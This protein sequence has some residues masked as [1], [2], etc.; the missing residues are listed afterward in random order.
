MNAENLDWVDL[1]LRQVVADA[2]GLPVGFGHDVRAGCLAEARFGAG[3][4]EPD[5][6]YVSVGTGIAAALVLR[7]QVYAG[8][9]YAGRSGTGRP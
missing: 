2:T 9:G 1:P 3:R 5:H 8:R 4:G 6:A 7:G